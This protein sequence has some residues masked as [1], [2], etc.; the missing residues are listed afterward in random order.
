M[1]PPYLLLTPVLVGTGKIGRDALVVPGRWGGEPA[2]ALALQ[3]CRDG[4]AIPGAT[5]P[6]YVPRPEDDLTRLTCRITATSPAGI[7]SVTTAALAVTH[8]APEPRGT[9]LEEIFDQ[10]SDLQTVAARPFF[11]GEALGFAVTGAGAS[12][13]AETGEIRIPTE[14]AVAESVT[15]T[16]RNSGGAATQS[17]QVTVEEAAEEVAE[18]AAGEAAGIAAPAAIRRMP[19][20]FPSEVDVPGYVPADASQQWHAIDWCLGNPDVVYGMQDSGGL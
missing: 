10:H 16:A 20:T 12:V 7:V 3:W 14:V 1:I 4:A 13:E 17:F 11:R 19:L 2:P 15:V 8:L 6:A 9:M 18:A 5:G